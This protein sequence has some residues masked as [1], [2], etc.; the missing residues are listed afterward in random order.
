MAMNEQKMNIEEQQLLE[1]AEELKIRK[2][3]HMLDQADMILRAQEMKSK[4]G[5][6]Q[7]KI[8]VE[9]GKLLLDADKTEKDFS[10]KLANVLSDIHR[11][12]NPVHKG[13]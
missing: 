1:R 4:M 11:H 6:E 2:E 9:H 5:L 12:N 8:K 3:K 13:D 7:Q 10:A